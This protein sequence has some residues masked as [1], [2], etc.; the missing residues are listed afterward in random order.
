MGRGL[1]AEPEAGAVEQGEV[2]GA[3]RHRNKLG[4]GL[5]LVL[6]VAALGHRQER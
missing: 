5:E 2:G 1:L 3:Q 4:Q 6:G